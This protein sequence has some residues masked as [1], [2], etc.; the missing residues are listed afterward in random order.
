M[1]AT[2]SALL[3]KCPRCAVPPITSEMETIK[4]VR[5]AFNKETLRRFKSAIYSRDYE[6]CIEC[7]AGAGATVPPSHLEP[8][9]ILTGPPALA[10]KLSLACKTETLSPEKRTRAVFKT[11]NRQRARD[12]SRFSG[13]LS[14]YVCTEVHGSRRGTSFR[15]RA[16]EK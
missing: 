8:R 9:S 16:C 6:R 1:E 5:E 4:G 11:L 10:W 2:L 13:Q 14:R 15:T 7:A 12:R 3:G